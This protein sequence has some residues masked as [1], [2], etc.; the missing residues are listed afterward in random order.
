[1]NGNDNSNLAAGLAIG[2][3][4]LVLVAFLA[5]LFSLRS[6]FEWA[7]VLSNVV[8]GLVG[9]GGAALGVYWTLRHQ[10]KRESKAQGRIRGLV[11]ATLTRRILHTYFALDWAAD[12]IA[13]N[14]ELPV[15]ELRK[16]LML[17]DSNALDLSVEQLAQMDA[18]VT[19]FYDG[20][21]SARRELDETLNQTGTSGTIKGHPDLWHLLD[22][23]SKYS[24]SMLAAY[25]WVLN[26]PPS[27]GD[28][29][30]RANERNEKIERLRLAITKVINAGG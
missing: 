1:M 24:G 8:G 18:R 12:T 15:A 17:A 10:E 27:Y 14:G 20:F 13:R 30:G 23:L 19:Y 7:T 29:E 6:A 21:L 3:G 9:A 22:A 11:S 5:A 28:T 4:C 2:V 16:H 26:T 25:S